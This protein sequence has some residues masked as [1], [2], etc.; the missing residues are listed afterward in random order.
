M[1]M[2]LVFFIKDQNDVQVVIDSLGLFEKA[3]S[4]KVNWEKSGALQVGHWHE[5]AAPS[6]PGGL[7]WGR[8]GMKFLGVYLGS[9]DFQKQNW[10]GVVEKVCARLSKWRWLLPQLSYRGRVLVANHLVDL[11][12][13]THCLTSSKEPHRRSTEDDCRFFLVWTTL[14]SGSSSVLTSK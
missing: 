2:M 11:M 1:Q 3:S 9:E 6:L 10:E 7:R 4:A 5:R 13:Q 12:A 14:D 8:G